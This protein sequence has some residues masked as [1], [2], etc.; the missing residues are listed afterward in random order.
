MKHNITPCNYSVRDHKS[1]WLGKAHIISVIPAPLVFFFSTVIALSIIFLIFFGSY[2][3]R[4]NV[5]GEVIT[6]PKTI[7][8]FS[9]TQGIVT[10]Q[11][12]KPGDFVSRGT[13]LYKI[14]S[15]KISDSGNVS[16]KSRSSI[17][18]QIMLTEQ[19]IAKIEE[20]K[21]QTLKNIQQQID[22]YLR[23]ISTVENLLRDAQEG[24]VIMEKYANSYMKYLHKG[25]INKD[26]LANQKSLFYQQQ[27]IYQNVYSQKIQAQLQA[28]KLKSDM[29]TTSVEFDNRI[30][31]YQYQR[32]ELEIKLTNID[33]NEAMLVTAPYDGLVESLSVTPG[34]MINTGD[35]LAQLSPGKDRLYY[36][37]FWLPNNSIPY[38]KIGDRVNIRYDA[39]P[40]EKFGQFGGRII[41][42]SN[43]A[44]SYQ[45]LK[46]YSNSPI[47][48]ST[49]TNQSYYKVTAILDENRFIYQGTSMEISSN[50]R[51]Q[52]TVFLE[53]RY[54]Y[55]WMF[56][57]FYGIK[58]S[59][60]E[61][62][63]GK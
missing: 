44:A 39:F 41:S 9:T 55:Q 23:V 3:R 16:I 63:I 57:P 14:D 33:L 37:V 22:E 56:T 43:V 34:Q 54:L 12:V 49:M 51:A 26:Q 21:D 17:N 13:R 45:E 32:S 5:I 31:E 20:D 60:M 4:I 52:T 48:S 6:S 1:S 46:S 15:S 42:I 11:Y 25:L 36:L 47:I 40:Y 38:V 62:D 28:E 50:M 30:S 27:G 59:L 19:I 35:S 24:L 2:T 7:T 18:R 29:I 10:E 58:S 61:Q 53:K 8:L